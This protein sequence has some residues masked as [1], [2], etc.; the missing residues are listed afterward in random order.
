LQPLS[1]QRERLSVILVHYR[2]PELAAAAVAAVLADAARSHF[3]VEGIVVDNGNDAA[4]QELLEALPFTRLEP[5]TNLG[6]AGGVNLGVER[7]TAATLVVLNPDVEVLPGCLLALA[8]TV[9]GRP[10]IAGPRFYWDRERRFLLPPAEAR[11]RMHELLGLFATRSPRAARFARARWRRQAR[12]HW[13]AGAALPSHALS[14]GL[15]AFSR[16][17]WDR[18]G[19]F[20]A[21]YRLYFEETDWL[22]RAELCGVPGYYVPSAGAIHL[23][24]QSA[25]REPLAASWFEE[26]AERYR[27]LHYGRAFAQFLNLLARW[28]PSGRGP[29]PRPPRRSVADAIGYSFPAWIEVSPNPTGYPAAAEHLASPPATWQVPAEL[30]DR[31][32]GEA[33]VARAVDDAGRELG[34]VD[35]S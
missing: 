30:R 5:G 9:R 35:L 10:A 2:T 3:E 6:F 29:D 7:A 1:P 21:A 32:A 13:N 31:L 20:D 14:G 17:A 22:R 4:G 34:E 27:R 28:L 16:A 8:E 33:M 11:G 15:L 26:S 18:V 12:R 23:H 19:P 24:G 25:A